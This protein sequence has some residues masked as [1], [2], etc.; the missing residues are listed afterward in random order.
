M[1]RTLASKVRIYAAMVDNL[2]QCDDELEIFAALSWRDGI[3]DGLRAGEALDAEHRAEL[4]RAD[5]LLIK[6]RGFIVDRF[7]DVYPPDR[8]DDVP[9]E[10]W[11][12]HLDRA[13]QVWEQR[14]K[15]PS[16]AAVDN[17]PGQG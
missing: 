12:W 5:D 8:G 6:Q 9:G 7:P 3:H 10:R 14:R 2:P 15:T 16:A 13:A 4:E 17:R 1:P 11:W